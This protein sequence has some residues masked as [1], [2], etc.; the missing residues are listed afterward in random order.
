[1]IFALTGES[2]RDNTLSVSGV[3]ELRLKG[4]EID[5]PNGKTDVIYIGS[6]KNLRKR[7]REHLNPNTKNG[8][9]RDF[10]KSGECSFRYLKF[11]KA[12][13]EEEAKLYS[14]FLST[15]GASP[16]CNKVRPYCGRRNKQEDK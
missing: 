4:K 5:Y 3:Y 9:I 14:L 6:A 2:V 8:R 1:M 10:L 12:W 11:P 13:E 7:I 15:Y 16:R